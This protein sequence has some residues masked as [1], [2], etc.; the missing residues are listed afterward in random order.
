MTSAPFFLGVI[1]RW[2]PAVPNA[3][4]LQVCGGGDGGTLGDQDCQVVVEVDGG[5]SI[6][7]L[8]FIR[9]YP[10]GRYRTDRWPGWCRSLGP[11]S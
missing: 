2:L 11:R 8:T 6:F 5:N 4:T 3:D 10:P 7:A 9:R 1:H